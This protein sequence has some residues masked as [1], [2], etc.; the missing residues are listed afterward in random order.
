MPRKQVLRDGAK[1]ALA[2]QGVFGT[3]WFLRQELVDA[4][5]TQ[6]VKVM[7]TKRLSNAMASMGA[8]GQLG[9]LEA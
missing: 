3:F 5:V 6:I 9:P 8:L 2:M 7:A 4:T 1:D